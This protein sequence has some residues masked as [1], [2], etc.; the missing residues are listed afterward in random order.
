MPTEEIRQDLVAYARRFPA[1]KDAAA[2]LNISEG[3]LSNMLNGYYPVSKPVARRLGWERQETR[4][5]DGPYEREAVRWVKEK[6]PM[7]TAQMVE[8][9]EAAY[10]Q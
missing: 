2:S 6:E 8:R 10:A 4:W 7:T 1:V 9:C 3:Y 5:R